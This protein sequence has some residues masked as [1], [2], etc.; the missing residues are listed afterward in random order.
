[1]VS[2]LVPEFLRIWVSECGEYLST[3]ASEKGQGPKVKR[4]STHKRN[5]GRN[6][7]FAE[8]A[9]VCM[10]FFGAC[11]EL[12]VSYFFTSLLPKNHTEMPIIPVEC[13]I[14]KADSFLKKNQAAVCF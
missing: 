6:L 5:Q 9:P 11:G 7:I 10:I 1:M 14:F 2:I 3:R 8:N 13:S 12:W 4:G